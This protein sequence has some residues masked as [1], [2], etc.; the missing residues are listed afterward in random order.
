VLHLGNRSRNLGRRFRSTSASFG[1]GES[2]LP[3]A[4]FFI[5]PVLGDLVLDPLA[6]KSVF[7]LLA[8]F[9]LGLFLRFFEMDPMNR[10]SDDAGLGVPLATK[11]LCNRALKI[12]NVIVASVEL[13]ACLDGQAAA[14]AKKNLSPVK[15]VAVAGRSS[16]SHWK[17]R[18]NNFTLS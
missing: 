7:T 3:F 5:G 14:L 15:F 8:L 9:F 12:K 11:R 17:S 10:G 2:R 6:R 1:C 13:F 16:V 18:R 4:C